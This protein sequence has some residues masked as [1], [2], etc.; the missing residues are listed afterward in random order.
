MIL[1]PLVALVLAA[2]PTLGQLDATTA[3]A[4]LPGTW[5]SGSQAVITGA[6]SLG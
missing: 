1:T 6:V 3:A 4:T 2:V 5:S